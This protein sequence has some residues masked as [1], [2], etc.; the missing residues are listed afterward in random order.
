MVAL[1]RAGARER[2]STAGSWSNAAKPVRHEET[3]VRD[4][5][6]TNATG[7]V[8]LAGALAR[9]LTGF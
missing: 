4:R 6:P 3:R 5:L 8:K 7:T 2:G 9:R 1:V